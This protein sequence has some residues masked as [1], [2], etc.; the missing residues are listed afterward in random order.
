MQHKTL[1]SFIITI[2][3][4]SCNN[5]SHRQEHT[6]AEINKPESAYPIKKGAEFSVKVAGITDGD[7]F[8]GLTGD[9]QEIKFCIYGIDAPETRNGGAQPFCQKSKQALSDLIFGKTVRIKV[10]RKDGWGRAVVWVYTPDGKDVSAE[11]I[12]AGMAWHFKKYADD[13]EYAELEKQARKQK[14]GLWANNNPVAPWE[15]RGNKK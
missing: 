13:A 8:K 14:I 5:N 3:F 2:L 10:Q 7:T 1:I 4:F 15:W 12:R 9:K 6:F 11:M